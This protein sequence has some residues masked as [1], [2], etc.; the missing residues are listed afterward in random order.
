[1]L[2]V[3]PTAERLDQ[4]ISGILTTVCNHSFHS[5]CIS[6]W[7]DSSCPVHA[8]TSLLNV[9]KLTS[10]Y[11]FTCTCKYIILFDKDVYMDCLIGVQIL[12]AAVRKINML[13]LW[14]FREPLDMCHLWVCGLWEVR[15]VFS[16][17]FFPAGGLLGRG[18]GLSAPFYCAIFTSFYFLVWFSVSQ[19]RGENLLS[20]VQILRC[21]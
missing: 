21:T 1:M 16:S 19:I 9:C 4:H 11:T 15:L 17:T 10:L 18:G 7:T 5:T 6:K 12:P 20:C 2:V 8:P 13:R 14:H 3:Y